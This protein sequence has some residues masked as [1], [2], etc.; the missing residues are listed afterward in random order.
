MSPDTCDCTT[1]MLR[2][3]NER[4]RERNKKLEEVAK[5][6]LLAV[7][8]Q[9]NSP[10]R[11]DDLKICLRVMGVGCLLLLLAGCHS[12][13]EQ[14]TCASKYQQILRSGHVLMLDGHRAWSMAEPLDVELKGTFG[15]RPA[16]PRE[17]EAMCLAGEGI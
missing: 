14:L 17:A 9:A 13:E 3:A 15:W 16:S 12:R 10:D 8:A 2:V 1:C 6:A 5:V 4:L 7:N 11:L